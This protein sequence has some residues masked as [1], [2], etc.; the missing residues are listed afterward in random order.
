[1][2]FKGVVAVNVLEVRFE[3]ARCQQDLRS[4]AAPNWTRTEHREHSM[5]ETAKAG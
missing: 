2:H 3:P 1:M 4:L 5:G